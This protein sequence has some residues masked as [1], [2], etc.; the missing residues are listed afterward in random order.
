VVVAGHGRVVQVVES[1]VHGEEGSTHLT[2]VIT[3]S[4]TTTT[5]DPEAALLA[6]ARRPVTLITTIAVLVAT[7]A[8]AEAEVG[9]RPANVATSAIIADVDDRARQA[10][11]LVRVATRA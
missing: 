1:I 7:E 4:T 11:R 9:E 8:V 3:I 2:T 10:A 6:L 5:A